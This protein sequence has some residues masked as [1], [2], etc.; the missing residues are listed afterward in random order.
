M[1]PCAASRLC[2]AEVRAYLSL[3]SNLGDRLQHLRAALR[4]LDAHPLRLEAQSS[5]WASAPLGVVQQ[6]EFFNMAAR[7]QHVESPGRLLESLQ[8][9]EAA[10]GKKVPFRWGPRTLDLDILLME[11]AVVSLDSL[12]VPHPRFHER[13]FVLE[14]LCE[15]DPWVMHPAL[16]LTARALLDSPG[17]LEQQVRCLGP[18]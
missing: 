13:R 7:I 9:I 14:P 5:V 3:G 8:A 10:C 17:V 2:A 16:K 6:P 18:L 1:R 11:D 15:L 4:L 12:Q